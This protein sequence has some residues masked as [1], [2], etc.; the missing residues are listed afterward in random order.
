MNIDEAIG[1]IDYWLGI[2]ECV[3]H[4]KHPIGGCLKCDLEEIRKLLRPVCDGCQRFDV[5]QIRPFCTEC[6]RAVRRD[7]YKQ[8][9]EP[10]GNS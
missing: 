9:Q 7:N 6:S 8:A 3:C 1:H 5:N 10:D 2:E 4:S